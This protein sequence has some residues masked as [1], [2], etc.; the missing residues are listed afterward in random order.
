MNL[1]KKNHKH[2]NLKTYHKSLFPLMFASDQ[3]NFDNSLAICT[4]KKSVFGRYCG[5]IHTPFDTIC[6]KEN[7][8]CISNML[9]NFSKQLS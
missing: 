8:D 9:C 5:R 2:N 4:L 3:A 6:K 1:A 7:T